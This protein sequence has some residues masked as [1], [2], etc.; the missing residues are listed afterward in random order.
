MIK[1]KSGCGYSVDLDFTYMFVELNIF[2]ANWL[3]KVKSEKDLNRNIFYSFLFLQAEILLIEILIFQASPFVAY[4]FYGFVFA[5]VSVLFL[6]CQEQFPYWVDDDEIEEQ[7]ELSK[8]LF[9]QNTEDLDAVVKSA[10]DQEIADIHQN[11]AAT[12]I[13]QK[14]SKNTGGKNTE[15]TVNVANGLDLKNNTIVLP[16]KPKSTENDDESKQC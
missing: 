15:I 6:F 8:S 7:E 9:Q 16:S 14:A 13:A 4:K 1:Y 11:Q 3:F 10:I 2:L 12:D 5:V